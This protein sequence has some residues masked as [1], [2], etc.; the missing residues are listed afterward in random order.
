MVTYTETFVTCAH[1]T[2]CV[3]AEAGWA[4]LLQ[5]IALE[6]LLFIRSWV[7]LEWICLQSESMFWRSISITNK[8]AFFC[9]LCRLS[10]ESHRHKMRM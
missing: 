2:A 6:L 9:E 10:V 7:F 4:K 1:E 5:L 8:Y 3:P